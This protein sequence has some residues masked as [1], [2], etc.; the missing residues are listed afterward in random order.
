MFSLES[1]LNNIEQYW[2][3]FLTIEK[4]FVIFDNIWK[5]LTILGNIGQYLAVQYL[6]VPNNISSHLTITA[7]T[8]Y[9]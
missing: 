1:D 4:Y 9:F 8:L 6:D 3:I 7:R 2:A 5:Y